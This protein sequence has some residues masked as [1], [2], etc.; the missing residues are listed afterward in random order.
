MT[1]TLTHVLH[2]RADSARFEAIDVDAV[3][4]AGSRAVRRR[5]WTAG[6]GLVASVALVGA[7]GALGLGGT[8]THGDEVG[9]PPADAPTI[10]WAE[11][12]MLHLAARRDDGWSWTS[13]M[14]LGHPIAA[15]VRTSVG[16]VVSDG[17]DVYS[18]VDGQ[19]PL[20]IGSIPRAVPGSAR[21]L[22][23]TDGTLAAWPG[24][25]SYFVLDQGT[26]EV[27][28]F[29]RSGSGSILALDDRSLY[30]ADDRG[31]VEIDVD[32]GAETQVGEPGDRPY[33]LAA[34][35]G[36]EVLRAR[37]GTVYVDRAGATGLAPIVLTATFVRDVDFSPDTRWISVSTANDTWVIDS[38]SGRRVELPLTDVS[39]MGYE[40]LD[41]DTLAVLALPVPDA[42]YR[43]LTCSLSTQ[44]CDVAVADL[45][46]GAHE[47]AGGAQF[48][49]PIGETY[50]TVPHG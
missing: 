39:T 2:E 31:V 46:E 20:G 42:H 40:W 47:L 44:A 6:T 11:G 15:Y 17:Q 7:F 25:S 1:E 19:E 50:F 33:V 36:R 35:D 16:Y 48:A 37:D 32:T 34:E 18:I 14:D 45:G 24:G 22:G 10:S 4:R 26:G 9:T 30:V 38:D 43:L 28:E 3:T 12:S 13:T 29:R 27:Q 21:M 8:E 23:D 5:R 41:D 49:L